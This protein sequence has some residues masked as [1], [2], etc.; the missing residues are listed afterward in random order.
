MGIIGSL[1]L[2]SHMRKLDWQLARDNSP[3]GVTDRYTLNLD[4]VSNRYQNLIEIMTPPYKKCKKKAAIPS[5][6][7]R[8][9]TLRNTARTS[10]MPTRT[11]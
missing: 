3:N 4:Q 6:T 8:T 5:R 1:T 9:P 2:G 11:F 10:I 7:S